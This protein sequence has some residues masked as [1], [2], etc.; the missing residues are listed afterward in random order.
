MYK[1]GVDQLPAELNGTSPTDVDEGTV[2]QGRKDAILTHLYEHTLQ[3]DKI[4]VKR[5]FSLLAGQWSTSKRY[6]VLT[7]KTHH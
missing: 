1:C 3:N 7:W 5:S 4:F 6:V 2:S